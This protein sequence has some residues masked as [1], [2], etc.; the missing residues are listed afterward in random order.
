MVPFRAHVLID[1]FDLRGSWNRLLILL[2]FHSKVPRLVQS[3]QTR[4]ARVV[5]GKMQPIS[6]DTPR[7]TFTASVNWPWWRDIAA[8]IIET[9]IEVRD[10]SQL[11]RRGVTFPGVNP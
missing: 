10:R 4:P 3:S 9:A 6:A 5:I 2:R 1:V 7:T 11:C 8:N